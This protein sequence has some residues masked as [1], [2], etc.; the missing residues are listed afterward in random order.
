MQSDQA[1]TGLPMALAYDIRALQVV[2]V[3]EGDFFKQGGAK[4][5]FN[6]RLEPSGRILMTS[7]RIGDGGATNLAN[8][9][10]ITFKAL[11]PT[12]VTSVEVVSNTPIGVA[13]K[14]LVAAPAAPLQLHIQ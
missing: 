9:A 8:L 5:S 14:S 7:T 3:S 10:T 12:S 6:S 2:T 13:G 4:T 1:V 11:V